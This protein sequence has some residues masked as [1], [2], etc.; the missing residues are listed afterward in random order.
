MIELV[1][2]F[3][4]VYQQLNKD[5]VASLAE[6]YQPEM[7]FIDP[8]HHVQGLPAFQDYIANLYANVTDCRFQFG[9]PQG[10]L[11]LMYVDWQMQFIHPRLAGGQA[12]SVP[13]VSQLQWQDGK[14]LKHRDF[15][16]GGAV[17]YEHVPVLGQVIRL[18]KRR[19]A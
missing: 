6:I 9:Q 19:M 2:Q 8:F 16:D 3:K 4:S 10:D 5:N 18:L 15:F 17:L 12:I 14:V 11:Q 1:E 13:G 7:T